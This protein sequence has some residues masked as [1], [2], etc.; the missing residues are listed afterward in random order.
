MLLAAFKVSELALRGNRQLVHFL[1]VVEYGSLGRSAEALNISVQA[2]S[3]S[4]KVLE[5]VVGARLFSRGPRGL[6]L[7]VF[8]ESLCGHARAVV[9]ELGRA[10]EAIEEIKG[11]EVGHVHIGTGPTCAAT[12]LPHVTS[13][14]MQANPGI[15]ISVIEARNALYPMLLH[16]EIDLAV[17]ADTTLLDPSLERE[18]LFYGAFVP[19]VRKEHPLALS[20][21]VTL[22]DLGVADWMLPKSPDACRVWLNDVFAK[23]GLRMPRPI[24]EFESYG[25][26]RAVLLRTDLVAFLPTVL[27]KSELEAGHLTTVDIGIEFRQPI[28]FVVRRNAFRSPACRLFI[29]Q[30]R[31]LGSSMGADADSAIG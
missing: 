29:S 3:K 17:V 9:A 14:F 18:T 22:E 12:L 19:V 24:I 4:I 21:S 10:A 26:A 15:R 1:T 16:G 20:Q 5:D 13:R 30:L 2:L 7:T 11:A 6:E 25:F 8:G 28:G 23:D 31:E 27:V